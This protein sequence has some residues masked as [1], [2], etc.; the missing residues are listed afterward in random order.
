MP[1]TQ[2]STIRLAS[3]LVLVA[4]LLASVGAAPQE[5][6]TVSGRVTGSARDAKQFASV[7]LAGPGRYAATTDTEGKFT[8]AKVKSGTY[9]IQVR[10]GDNVAEFSRNL[11]GKALIDL[12]VKW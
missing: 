3:R 2:R 8:I 5:E 11:D 12:V 9:T 1:I 7:S 10:Q 6:V 4:A